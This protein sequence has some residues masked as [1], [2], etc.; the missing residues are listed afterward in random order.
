MIER[1]RRRPARVALAL[2]C[3]GIALGSAGCVSGGE[4]S[5]ARKPVAIER[6]FETPQPE[7]KLPPLPEVPSAGDKN[8]SQK[9]AVFKKAYK[10]QQPF[11]E[12]ATIQLHYNR[13]SK[14][15]EEVP[16]VEDS[17]NQS[18]QDGNV[19]I[20]AGKF[21]GSGFLT[22]AP[23]GSEVVI[24][25][26]H[27]VSVG[28][29]AK[30]EV[31]NNKDQTVPVSDGCYMYENKGEF[32]DLGQA[33][34]DKDSAGIEAVDVAVLRLA[35]P[36]GG[37]ALKLAASFPDRG[38]W[39]QF[40]NNQQDSEPAYPAEYTGLVTSRRPSPYGDIALTGVEP[41]RKPIDGEDS[42][43]IMPGG[44]G[45]LV[46]LANKAE[47]VGISYGGGIGYDGANTTEELYGVSFDAPV[48]HKTGIIPVHADI[49]G[50]G[51][52]HHALASTRY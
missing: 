21:K 24:T 18:L 6:C 50:A 33:Y 32:V 16:L 28:D 11:L 14:F 49:I 22:K 48:G 9:I 42:Y 45:G 15:I 36:L 30:I 41:W 35:K 23:D 51:V 25:A 47:V 40:V 26:A 13:S 39:V 29:L 19:M 2:A 17:V 46:S 31:S 12:P 38:T 3:A 37:T 20:E 5:A 52:L 43:T 1:L 44:S 7:V 34:S 27:V 10:Q 8:F 4:A